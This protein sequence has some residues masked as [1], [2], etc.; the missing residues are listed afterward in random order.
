MQRRPVRLRQLRPCTPTPPLRR[1][2]SLSPRRTFWRNNLCLTGL[3]RS[4]K[5]PSGRTKNPPARSGSS[6]TEIPSSLTCA[7]LSAIKSSNSRF[8]SLSTTRQSAH[9]ARKHDPAPH[10]P[11]GVR[12]SSFLHANPRIPTS[13]RP[14]VGTAPQLDRGLKTASQSLLVS[15]QI[16]ETAL[17]ELAVLENQLIGT[18]RGGRSPGVSG[19]TL[20]NQFE[21]LDFSAIGHRWRGQYESL[22][23]K[24]DTAKQVRVHPVF[25]GGD[26]HV[27]DYFVTMERKSS[28]I[29]NKG[30]ESLGL[31]LRRRSKGVA[32]G[33]TFS[34]AVADHRCHSAVLGIGEK[35]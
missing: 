30:P 31:L 26:F 29:G 25:D 6:A 12:G 21:S 11:P 15:G 9:A 27:M 13:D 23:V 17:R 4:L 28:G 22:T 14:R 2:E 35:T 5:E 33:K 3:P 24:L 32:R 8:P 19:Q 18:P 16:H 1:E 20:P 34:S 7:S 10:S